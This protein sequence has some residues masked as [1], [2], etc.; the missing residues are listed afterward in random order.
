MQGLGVVVGCSSSFCK[1]VEN[2]FSYGSWED[3]CKPEEERAAVVV[4]AHRAQ[5][6]ERRG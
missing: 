3:V 4:N 1:T 6:T 5:E 2:D